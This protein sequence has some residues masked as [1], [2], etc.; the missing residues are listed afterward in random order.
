[1]TRRGASTIVVL[2]LLVAFAG[3]QQAP[4]A[5]QIFRA[6]ADVVLVDVSV[7]ENGRPV[8]G[9]TA[10]DFDV[11]DNGTRQRVETAEAAAVPIDLTVVVDASGNPHGAWIPP[12]NIPAAARRPNAHV[13]EIAALLRPEDRLRVLAID[14]YGRQVVA[15]RPA[16]P[17]DEFQLPAAGGMAALYDTLVAALLKPVEP[18]RRHVV[19]VGTKGLDTVSATTVEHVRDIAERSG[20]L[21]HVVMDETTLDNEAALSAF[22]GSFMGLSKPVRKFW[23]PHQSRIVSDT[24]LTASG[25]ILAEAAESTGGKLHVTELLTEPT[26]VGTFRKAFEDFR[27]SYVLRYTPRDVK[28]EG[29]HEITVGVPSRPN[30]VVRARRGYAIDPIVPASAAAGTAAMS[31]TA[32][33]AGAA[34]TRAGPSPGAPAPS[35]LLTTAEDLVAAYDRRDYSIVQAN[36]LRTTDPSD[37]IRKFRENGNPWPATPARE[38]AFVLELA[39]AGLFS[40]EPQA[41]EAARAMLETHT[42]FIRHPLEADAFE[43]QWHHVAL[44]ILE[45]TIRPDLA[46]P[47][48][49]RALDRFPTEPRFVLARAIVA[50]QRTRGSGAGYAEAIA[51]YEAALAHPEIAHEARVRLGWLLTRSGRPA[52]ALAGLDEIDDGRSP[53]LPMRY[54]RQL[55]RGH[56][57]SALGRHD[58]AMDAYRVAL[59]L[60]PD[61]QSASVALMNTQLQA[62]D[63]TSAKATAEKIQTTPLDAPDPWWSYWQA[64]LRFYR[65]A[66]ARI[67]E[68]AR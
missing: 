68:M 35:R 7:R 53:D 62:G 34:T 59:V 42:R 33:T 54:L 22:Q 46:E 39:E 19:I 6:G 47:F 64:D 57:L 43:R 17:F 4:P 48:V 16:G 52:D 44:A 15:P 32:S 13:R 8:T 12:V 28:R 9:L 40:R 3:A 51:R 45:G 55:F 20:A 58:A 1:V 61:A 5:P 41:R 36:L 29:W 56:A 31:A 38:A 21:L 27:Q 50:D 30:A 67:R 11:R 2:A 25:Q 18:D 65:G 14:T 66:I 60:V 26:L 49:R 24:R 63:R 23:V 37:V 10:A